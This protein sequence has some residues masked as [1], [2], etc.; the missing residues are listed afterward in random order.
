[1]KTI[2]RISGTASQVF[3]LVALLAEQQGHKTLGKIIEEA[4]HDIS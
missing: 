3:R 4:N 2:I 1:M